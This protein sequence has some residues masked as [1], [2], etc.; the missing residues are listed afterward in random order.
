MAGS[1]SSFF[2]LPGGPIGWAAG[3][4][5][6]EEKSSF[7][8]NQFDLDLVTWD[9]SNGNAPLPIQGEFDV[10]EYFFEGQ[11][12]IIADAPLVELLEVTGAIRFADY[13]TV[14]SNEAWST[15]LRYSPGFGLTLR[16]T[17][18]EAVRA[19][20]INELF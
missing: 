3:I 13:S 19:P 8:V 11:A 7:T 17:L 4:E 16:G 12:P 2:E 20:N 18:A 10:F 14:G 5:Y 15:G 9:G 6:R 1:T